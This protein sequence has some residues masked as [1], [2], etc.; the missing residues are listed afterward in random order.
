M[1]SWSEL[2]RGRGVS[3]AG[4]LRP[5]SRR[6]VERQAGGHV[7]LVWGLS[8]YPTKDLGAKGDAGALVTQSPAIADRA[9]DTPELRYTYTL[10]APRRRSEQPPRRT[11]GRDP[12]SSARLARPVQRSAHDGG[13]ALPGGDQE[14][15]RSPFGA[16]GG[17]IEPR[18]SSV[19]GPLS[20]ARSPR[21]LPQRLRR[22]NAGA[23][24]DSGAPARQP[25][26]NQPKPTTVCSTR[27]VTRR[28][29]VEDVP[30][31]ASRRRS[32][33]DHCQCER[34]RVVADEMREQN[35]HA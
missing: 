21:E 1:N 7:R 5:I 16:A 4:R 34:L 22:R 30:P 9:R 20:R 18:L 8:F 32:G 2:C 10:R 33:R 3:L 24:P 17:S 19:R 25:G 11:A 12:E 28:R 31:A 26:C 14:P 15:S 23:L 29:S 27:N 13:W 35:R 6:G